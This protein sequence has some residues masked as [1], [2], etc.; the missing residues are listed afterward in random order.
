MYIVNIRHYN[1][2]AIVKI[3]YLGRIG[4]NILSNF[5]R[6]HSIKKKTFC[7]GRC[8]SRCWASDRTVRAGHTEQ[9]T[10]HTSLQN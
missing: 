8:C 9:L 6:L 3:I 1:S 5:D 7:G 4:P 2:V 10:T